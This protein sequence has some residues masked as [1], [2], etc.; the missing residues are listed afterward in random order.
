MFLPVTEL[1]CWHSRTT[2]LSAG[3]VEEGEKCGTA[4]EPWGMIAVGDIICPSIPKGRNP[5]LWID[6]KVI[7]LMIEAWARMI[8]LYNITYQMP[9]DL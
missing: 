3:A 9:I 6:K 7:V 5:S 4:E 1:Q 8:L 2:L